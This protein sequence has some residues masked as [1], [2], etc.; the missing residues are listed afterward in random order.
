MMFFLMSILLITAV[1][2]VFPFRYAARAGGKENSNPPTK[3]Q[4]KGKSRKDTASEKKKQATG[5]KKNNSSPIKSSNKQRKRKSKKVTV[6]DNKKRA[7]GTI[8]I[9]SDLP[10]TNYSRTPQ[11]H[12]SFSLSSSSG[13]E[14]VLRLTPSRQRG[15]G[16]GLKSVEQNSST[17]VMGSKLYGDKCPKEP[18]FRGNQVVDM[19]ISSTSTSTSSSEGTSGSKSGKYI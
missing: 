11:S 18:L 6:K 14:P 5:K 19:D 9:A 3:K 15:N 7:I 13:S 8:I 12:P 1:I 16:H 4:R 2:R 17:A 10:R